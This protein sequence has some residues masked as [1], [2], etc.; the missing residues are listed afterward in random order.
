MA[1]EKI[2]NIENIKLKVK[3]NDWKEAIRKSGGILEEN[4]Y[5]K[6]KYIEDMI[7]AVE[8]LGPYIVISPHIAIAHARPS[9]DV[10]KDGM[11]LA[12]LEK[13]IKFGNKENDPVDIVF[14]LCAKSQQSHLKALEHLAKVLED[15]E[16]IHILR[17]TEDINEVYN[18]LNKN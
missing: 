17:N 5:V 15:G 14:S 4:G 10:L 8:N 3:A 12:I 9:D 18:L 6:N 7:K 1:E 16:N 2:M 13:P 11:S